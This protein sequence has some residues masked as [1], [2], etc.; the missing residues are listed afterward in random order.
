LRVAAGAVDG[1]HHFLHDSPWREEEVE[2]AQQE[3]IARR[4][5]SHHD[6][7]RLIIDDTPFE[8]E[9]SKI[10]GLGIH[11]GPKGLVKGLCAV[12]A[13]VRTA[14]ESWCWAIRGYRPKRD[15]PAGAFRS[16]IDLA[17]S[18]IEGA[19]VLGSRVVVLMD[20]W[21]ACKRLLNRIEAHGWRY[22]AAIKVNR[23]LRVDGRTTAARHLAKGPRRYVTVRLSKRRKVRVARR[24]A[25]LPGVGPVAVFITKTAARTKFLISN[26]LT[27]TPRQAVILYA[28]R[29]LIETFHRDAKQHLGL[30]EMWARSWQAVQ[31]HW[32]LCAVAYNAL[33]AWNCSQ[34]FRHRPFGQ[35]IRAFREH[36]SLSEATRWH[37]R[38][39][40]V[41]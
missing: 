8:R 15:C 40:R 9:G 12:T 37:Q 24:E 7:A 29:F 14:R 21:Y 2:R 4:A 30:G 25:V 18:I 36:V 38:L 35:I 31:R 28:E 23:L 10:E 33:R 41:A 19:C 3:M 20:T 27:M 17:A 34:R 16:K 1:L 26:D 5:Q 13:I 11:H 32:T 6:M 22:V 39:Q